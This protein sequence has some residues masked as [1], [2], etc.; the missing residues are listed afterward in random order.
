MAR[1]LADRLRQ[2]GLDVWLDLEELKPADR[3]MESLENA[4]ARADAF[5]VYVG[6]SGI[7][8]WVAREVRVALERNTDDAGFH[9]I[10]ILGSGSEPESLPFFLAQH[11]W[12]DMRAGFA[13]PADLKRLVGAILKRRCETISLISPNQ[14]PFRGLLPFDVGH[15]HLF[16][17]RDRETGELLEQ[18]R[19]NRFLAVVGSSG[20][21]KSSLV[22][23]GLVP[24]LNRGRFHERGGWVDSWRIAIFR[25]GADPFRELANAL[26][27]LD[28]DL[29]AAE[30]IKVRDAC[31]KPLDSG[32]QGLADC[33]AG[34]VPRGERT[35]LVVDQ[36]E[37]LFTLT[38]RPEERRRF[39]DSLL[40]AVDDSG[41]RPIHCVITLRADFF[42][43][44]WEHPELPNRIAA[45]Q[46]AVRRVDREQLQEI[47]EKPAAMA[48]VRLEPGLAEAM[49]HDAGDE[50]GNLPLL[51][52]ALLEL[53]ERRGERPH[54]DKPRDG[55]YLTHAS[56][57]AIGRL[58][59][60]LEHRAEEIYKELDAE[61]KELARR[62]ILRLTEAGKGVKATRRPVKREKIETLGGS[63]AAI[64]AVLTRLVD[65]RLLTVGRDA[66]GQDQVEVA[67]EALIR[68]WRRLRGWLEEDREFLLWRKRLQASL[69]AREQVLPPLNPPEG[70]PELSPLNPP[71]GTPE[72]SPLNPPVGTDRAEG[73]LLRGGLLA[74]ALRWKAERGKDLDEAQRHFI[75]VSAKRA[76]RFQRLKAAVMATMTILATIAGIAAVVAER[77]K[78]QAEAYLENAKTAVHTMLTE[79]GHEALADVPQMEG[80]RQELLEKAREFYE[81]FLEQEPTD[82]HLRQ[83]GA[84]AHQRVGDIHRILGRTEDAERAY[85]KAIEQ[86]R[87]L[88]RELPD[89]PEYRRRLADVCNW[90]AELL[91]KSDRFQEAREL[92]DEAL[93]LQSNLAGEFRNR[94]AYRQELARTHYSRGLASRQSDAPDD[95]EKDFLRAIELLRELSTQS[96]EEP[97]YRQELARSYKNLGA[98]LKETGR[99][100]EARARCQQAVAVYQELVQQEPGRREYKLELA[101]AYNNL[102]NLLSELEELE[103]A[104][105]TNREALELFEELAAAVPDLRSEL[106]NSY[107]SRGRMLELSGSLRQAEEAYL[108]AATIFEKLVGDF[109]DRSEYKVRFGITLANVGWLQLLAG[110]PDGAA[111]EAE[112]LA[113]LL[114]E[115]PEAA[116]K[117]LNQDYEELI[118]NL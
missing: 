118:A 102:G 30:R 39:I 35:L 83:E 16:F 31:S 71:V 96:P 104:N 48:G 78:Q 22:R 65:Q 28:G 29:D 1:E 38:R 67:H 105:R 76:R 15:A 57:E 70:T 117:R 11:Q 42:A 88:R 59:G 26:C 109:P 62:V 33:I 4:L 8:G 111:R 115:L 44:C 110:D 77:R 100:A 92:Y 89:H 3:W 37:E 81:Q 45:N 73:T 68:G 72:L 101:K 55:V 36:F 58:R 19:A 80:V 43:E 6:K 23:A 98:L 50:P 52:H 63:E 114:P 60:A 5:A 17:G 75:E 7:R 53:W 116:R 85:R 56:Y 25:P 95:S 46:F 103:E 24:A 79:V 91:R 18:L 93:S 34:L 107:N 12:L 9:V 64:R 13:E 112:K 54:S 10:P 86:L 99:P 49:L 74:E 69:E 82:P 47:I 2:A 20:S 40:R 87:T 27:D 66:E 90:L 51:Q 32:T 61:G 14:P 21:G 97:E 108:E 106:A 84:S 113:R 94:P 41:E